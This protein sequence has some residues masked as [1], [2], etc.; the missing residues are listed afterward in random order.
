MICAIILAAGRSRRM[1]VQKLLLPVGGKPMIACV[2]DAVLA[3]P[4]DHVVVVVGAD[5]AAIADAL[6]GRRVHFVT[7]PEAEG[8]MLGSVRCGLSAVPQDAAAALV[9]PGDQPGITSEVVAAVVEAFRGSTSS[10]RP[11]PVEGRSSGRGLVVPTHAGRR[12]HPLLIALRY[13]DEILARYDG[14]GLRGLLQAHPEDVLEVEVAAPGAVEDVD[15]PEQYA[16]ATARP[17]RASV[18]TERP[19]PSRRRSSP[20][21]PDA[22]RSAS[23]RP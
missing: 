22:Q 14:A 8:E 13:R 15:T 6:A 19:G 16:Q 1:G 20:R 18:A 12:G 11:E 4:V 23:R 21:S 2:V 5:G 10:P 9:A 3:G 17:I 7:N